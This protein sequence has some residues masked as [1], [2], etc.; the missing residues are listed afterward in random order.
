MRS[1]PRQLLNH[2]L[3]I[4]QNRRSALPSRGRGCLRCRTSNCCRRQRFSAISRT[5][6]LNAAAITQTRKRTTVPPTNASHS[7]G[8]KVCDCQPRS[9]WTAILRP[10]AGENWSAKAIPAAWEPPTSRGQGLA[11]P[12]EARAVEG[13]SG[14]E[15]RFDAVRASRMTGF[16]GLEQDIGVCATARARRGRLVS[17]GRSWQITAC[18]RMNRWH[19]RCSVRQLC[20][21]GVL[22]AT[23]RVLGLVTASQMASASVASFL[24]RSTYGFTYW[25]FNG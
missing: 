8:A 10:T 6:G 3:A 5:L 22:V 2:R 15:S 20:C 12:I 1:E 21:S 7:R 24:C 23:N 11:E 17:W 18:W 9:P 4:I 13:L 16:V 25:G 19:V 14:S